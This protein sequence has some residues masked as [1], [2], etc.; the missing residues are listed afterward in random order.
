MKPRFENFAF[1]LGTRVFSASKIFSSL[2]VEPFVGDLKSSLRK[3]PR[4]DHC[5]SGKQGKQRDRMTDDERTEHTDIVIEKPPES[6]QNPSE[7]DFQKLQ[8]RLAAAKEKQAERK[9]NS[10]YAAMLKELEEVGLEEDGKLES[11]E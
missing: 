7:E 5:E 10:D 8:E 11:N 1:P 2:M 6:S 9:R 4:V 3:Q